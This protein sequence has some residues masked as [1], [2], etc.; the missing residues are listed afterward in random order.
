MRD[1]DEDNNIPEE[2]EVL[3]FASLKYV[4]ESCGSAHGSTI[5]PDRPLQRLRIGIQRGQIDDDL[6]RHSGNDM[7]GRI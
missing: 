4:M 2:E 3:Y 5:G 6:S 1:D 7:I